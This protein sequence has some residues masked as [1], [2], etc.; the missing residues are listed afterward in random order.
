M[1]VDHKVI[2]LNKQDEQEFMRII[3]QAFRDSPQ[4]PAL[5]TK[6]EQT[7]TILSHLLK[8]YE[9]T[10]TIKVFGIKK[11]DAVI[12]VG[13]CVDSDS[14]TGVFQLVKLMVPILLSLGLRGL[15]Q[16]WLYS[17]NKPHYEKKYLELLFYG[18]HTS[19]QQQ[20]YGASLLQYL[21]RYAKENGYGGVI[22]VTNTSRPAFRFYKKTGWVVDK[23]FHVGTYTICWVRYIV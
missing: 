10:G 11:N 12:C 15:Y 5:I 13:L 7:V 20:G 9:K 8:F 6:P 18:T 23:E 17:K 16:F 14:K 21:Y 22:G 2:E 1:S 4:V 19:Y 3:I